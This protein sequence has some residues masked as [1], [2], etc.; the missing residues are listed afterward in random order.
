MAARL[1]SPQTQEPEFELGKYVRYGRRML[2]YRWTIAL[3]VVLGIAAAATKHFVSPKEYESSTTVLIQ[4]PAIPEEFIKSTVQTSSEQY[5]STL[6]KQVM[7]R[8]RLEKI[9]L[10][11][12]LYPNERQSVT[13]D[14]VVVR[15]QGDIEIQAGEGL[16][17][18]TYIGPDP[19]TTQAVCRQ[20]ADIY[21]Q[22]NADERVRQATDTAEF[23]K[24]RM[25]DSKAKLDMKETE[26]KNFREGNLDV[27]PA[28]GGTSVSQ[29]EL[30]NAYAE[31]ESLDESIRQL[32]TNKTALAGSLMTEEISDDPAR[33]AREKLAD[34]RS[35]LAAA[36]SKYTPQHPDVTRL[37][38]EVFRQEAIVRSSPK[39]TVT[40][41]ANPQ[42]AAELRAVKNDLAD[43]EKRLE[44]V[45]ARIVELEQ[46]RKREPGVTVLLT[47]LERER[48]RLETEYEDLRGKFSEAERSELLESKN[49]GEQ[50][51]ILDAANLPT[52]ASGAGL[53]KLSLAGLLAGFLLGLVIALV[54]VLLDPHI[55]EA[56]D[57]R[58]YIDAEVLVEI[59]QFGRRH[60]ARPTTKALPPPTQT[61]AS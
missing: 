33:A 4:G 12:D 32:R 1:P 14:D 53:I 58:K 22:E 39:A 57:I 54:R 11:M 43:A 25:V 9:I 7:S 17:K 15:M 30:Q 16:F 23:L 36:E 26:I 5:I 60:L 13:M 50:F 31:K 47:D 61:P 56:D 10:D 38:G 34:L 18:I 19:K 48:K 51:K 8:S 28:Q 46:V 2:N 20:L 45:Q 44:T 52:R 41:R 27:I 35:K 3:M 55:Y 59:P 42:A 37:R 49:K 24:K 40:R 29:Q 6:S 21:I